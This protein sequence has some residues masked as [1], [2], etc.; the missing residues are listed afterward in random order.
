[1]SLYYSVAKVMQKIR[2]S[3]ILRTIF[4][5]ISTFMLLKGKKGK[6]KKKDAGVLHP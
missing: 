2:Y 6:G 5:F 1:M 3:Q 4:H